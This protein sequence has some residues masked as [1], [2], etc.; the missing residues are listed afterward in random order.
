[1]PDSHA[2]ILY[3][4]PLSSYCHKV[5]IALYENAIPFAAHTVDL[6]DPAARA[7]FVKVWPMA[8]FPVLRDAAR[9]RTV[10]ESTVIIEYLQ[11]HYPGPVKLVPDDP[12]GAARA[13]ATDRFYDLHVHQ[14]MQKIVTDKLR[15]VDGH[16]PIGVERAKQQL[17]T[18]LR[19]AEAEMTGRQWATGEQF[20]LADCAAAPALFYAD[21]IMPLGPE[22]PHLA[23]YLGRLT[24]RPSYARALAEAQPHF[25]RF[26]G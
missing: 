20:S 22:F 18:A 13:R 10:P 15:P 5:L 24:S 17:R 25:A 14:H 16:D 11:R 3:M 4:H 8:Q 2:L 7:R 6:G 9:N 19:L 12:E 23:A 21:R 1:M 26:P